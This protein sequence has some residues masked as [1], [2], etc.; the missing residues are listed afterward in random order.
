MQNHHRDI[1]SPGRCL[2]IQTEHGL[3]GR[4][5]KETD[6]VES[7]KLDYAI[8][9]A[10]GFEQSKLL[11]AV[12]GI[13]PTAYSHRRIV[14]GKIYGKRVA[15]VEGG[16]GT[17]NT[18]Q[19]L[20]A[21]LEKQAVG[22]VCQV[23]IGGAYPSSGL[24][25]GDIAIA[26][27]EIQGEFGVVTESGWENGETIG[28]PLLDREPPI[29][30]RIPLDP[31]YVAAAQKSAKSTADTPLTGTG[32]FLTLQ[33]VTGSDALA[34]ELDQRFGAICENMEGASAAHICTLY[35]VPMVEIRGISN[36]VQKRDLSSWDIPLAAT[37]AQ[38]VLLA[39]IE[40]VTP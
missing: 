18:A 34:R 19:A 4:Q 30:N 17:T 15:I 2:H 29:Y 33:N 37:R 3:E 40:N 11:E 32:A 36:V 28:I 8:I 24:G 23:G 39:M 9:T 38:D 12:G 10:T 35:D 13:E 22:V 1:L 16:I 25:V 5:K 31:D 27:E 6:Q 26:T 21:V 20:T 14:Y 7:R